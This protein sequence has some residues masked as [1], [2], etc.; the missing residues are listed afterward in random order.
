MQMGLRIPLLGVDKGS[1]LS[2]V[3][4]EEDRRVVE[5]DPGE[6]GDQAGGGGRRG[7][8]GSV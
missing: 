5:D 8:E 4:Y 3:T 7:G 2:R 1:E 6:R